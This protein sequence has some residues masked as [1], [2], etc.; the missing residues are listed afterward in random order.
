MIKCERTQ[1]RKTDGKESRIDI[2]GQNEYGM[3][4]SD[5]VLD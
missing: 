3:I 4:G 2:T 5:L 1:G